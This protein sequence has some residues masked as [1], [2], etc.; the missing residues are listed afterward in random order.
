ML[1]VPAVIAASALLSGVSAQTFRRTAA[2]PSLGCILP[3]V[4]RS[5]TWHLRVSADARTKWISLPDVSGSAL[6][7]GLSRRPLSSLSK[8][9][10]HSLTRFRRPQP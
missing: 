2:C 4:S 6:G 7:F 3:P 10:S 9:L 1:F 5:V 8:D